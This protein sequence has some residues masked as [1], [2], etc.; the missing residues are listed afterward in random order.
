M[1]C[2]IYELTAAALSSGNLRTLFVLSLTLSRPLC[3]LALNFRLFPACQMRPMLSCCTAYTVPV[4]VLNSGNF[5]TLLALSLTVSSAL[6]S[7]ALNFR[8]S[9]ACYSDSVAT[10][11]TMLLRSPNYATTLPHQTCIP[12]ASPQQ[13]AHVYTL[14]SM[15]PIGFLNLCNAD[16]VKLRAHDCIAVAQSGCSIYTLSTLHIRSAYASL[17]CS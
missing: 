10:A 3:S 7:L 13:I 6:C 1:Y 4:P 5:R 14:L 11:V 15:L 12:K 17:S 16:L 2:T 9:P 8:P